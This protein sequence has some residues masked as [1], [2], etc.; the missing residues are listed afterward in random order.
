METFLMKQKLKDLLASCLPMARS[1][2]RP[3]NYKT[4]RSTSPLAQQ[5]SSILDLKENSPT[6]TSYLSFIHSFI[7]TAFLNAIIFL[8]SSSWLL[9]WIFQY[10]SFCPLSPYPFPS[11]HFYA[12]PFTLSLKTNLFY[13]WICKVHIKAW[14]T[15]KYIFP[16]N[17]F[18]LD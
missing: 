18:I 9:F 13:G 3:L 8:T 14:K 15:N 4:L 2:G 7:H 1:F 16:N 10:A 12:H 11:L 6:R 17:L 5:K